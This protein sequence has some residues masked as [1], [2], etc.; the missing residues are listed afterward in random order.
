MTPQIVC[1]AII[2]PKLLVIPATKS[3]ASYEAHKTSLTKFGHRIY[4]W[5]VICYTRKYS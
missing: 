5:T 2:I 1:N 4:G 3:T